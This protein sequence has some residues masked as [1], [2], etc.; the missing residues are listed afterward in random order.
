[1]TRDRSTVSREEMENNMTFLRN[2]LRQGVVP[3]ETVMA[4]IND[5]L[6]DYNGQPRDTRTT[7]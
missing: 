5:A 7:R 1:M 6:D 2:A 3:R 4:T